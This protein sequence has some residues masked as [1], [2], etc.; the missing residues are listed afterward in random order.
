MA[1]IE[2]IFKQ[3]LTMPVGNPVIVRESTVTKMQLGLVVFQTNT[4]IHASIFKKQ[5]SCFL[6]KLL[7]ST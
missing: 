4:G 6:G 2:K 5:S 7:L 1:C 3:I